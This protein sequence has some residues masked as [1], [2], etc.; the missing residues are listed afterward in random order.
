MKPNE[1]LRR[2]LEV[3]VVVEECDPMKAYKILLQW[4]A[5]QVGINGAL[6][7]SKIGTEVFLRENLDLNVLRSDP[8]DW[9]GELYYE[10]QLQPKNSPDL[11]PYADAK[12]KAESLD[13]EEKGFPEIILD[14]ESGTGRSMMA[15][16]H[17]WGSQVLL[18]GIEKD[19]SLFRICIVNMALYNIPSLVVLHNETFDIEQI[20]VSDPV[21]G[22]ANNW[23]GSK[24]S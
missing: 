20:R 7:K 2:C 15:I 10:L 6:S 22:Y 12:S 3:I 16:S 1:L 23:F 14:R 18:Y 11:I 8:K 24:I 19:K 9:L 5:V 21:W 13:V 17:H 4:I